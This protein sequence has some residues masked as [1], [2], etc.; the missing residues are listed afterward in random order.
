MASPA[1]SPRSTPARRARSASTSCTTSSRSIPSEW[2][3]PPFD[4]ALVDK[5]GLGKVRRR[6]RRS[7]PEGPGGLLPGRAT[8]HSRRR[9]EVARQSGVCCRGR[10]RNRFA[11]LSA[12]RAPS[13]SAGGAAQVPWR[14]HARRRAGPRRQSHDDAGRQGRDRTRTGFERRKLGTRSAK[15]RSLQHESHDRQPGLAP[16]GGT[17]DA[18]LGRRQY[19]GHRRLRRQGASALRRGEENDRRGGPPPG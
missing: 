3:S 12:D 5:P 11:A 16:G 2:S 4:A 1:S 13:R 18:G 17:L 15:R 6:P 8:R 19:A 9:P 10:R 7:E 14:L